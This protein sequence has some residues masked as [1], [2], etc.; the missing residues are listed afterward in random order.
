MTF[1]V[2]EFD[3]EIRESE[4]IWKFKMGNM[5]SS[6]LDFYSQDAASRSLLHLAQDFS[7]QI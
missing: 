1:E 3:Y 7:A 6:Q 2:R 4:F 5:N